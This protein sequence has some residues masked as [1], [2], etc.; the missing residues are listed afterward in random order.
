MNA[1]FVRWAE[2]GSRAV[3]CERRAPLRSSP[4]KD[5]RGAGFAFDRARR[6]ETTA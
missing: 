6:I 1:E 2:P 5:Y 3:G 4:Y